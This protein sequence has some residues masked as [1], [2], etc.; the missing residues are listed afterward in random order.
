MS[1]HAVPRPIPRS[2]VTP[3][4]KRFGVTCNAFL[5]E[6]SPLKILPDAYYEPWELV[7]QHLPLL[8]ESGIRTAVDRL[9]VL[10]TSRLATEAEWRRAYVILAFLTHAYVWGG[11]KPSEVRLGR[12]Y[13]TSQ[14]TDLC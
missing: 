5:P 1:P 2:K 10:S 8:I 3:E 11:D 6:Q 13:R 14:H 12:H 4:L 9:P 7:V